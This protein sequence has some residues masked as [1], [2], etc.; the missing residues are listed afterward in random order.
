M[1]GGGALGND[2]LPAAAPYSLATVIFD[3]EDDYDASVGYGW[4]NAFNLTSS[5][6]A[7]NGATFNG[8]SFSFQLGDSTAFGGLYLTD[9]LTG[10]VYL[11]CVPVGTNQPPGCVSHTTL[12]NGCITSI[13]GPSAVCY[14]TTTP[15][16]TGGI[17]DGGK[18][19]RSLVI[20][21]VGAVR[22]YNFVCPP[23]IFDFLTPTTNSLLLSPATPMV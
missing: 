19:G 4:E 21:C 12:C 3:L 16:C 14:Q 6:E 17:G 7:A 10:I 23:S 11:I 8:L 22:F 18:G 13:T 9:P 20:T 5:L 2:Q 15:P 1:G